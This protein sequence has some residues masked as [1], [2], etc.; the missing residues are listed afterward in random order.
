MCV[1]SNE[2]CIDSK[3]SAFVQMKA[4]FY[5]FISLKEI[6]VEIFNNMYISMISFSKFFFVYS[7][8]MFIKMCDA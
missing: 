5:S 3:E 6:V 1:R 2:M 7:S 8:N 4:H